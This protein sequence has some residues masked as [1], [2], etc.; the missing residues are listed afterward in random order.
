LAKAKVSILISFS[1]SM[2]NHNA[3][4]LSAFENNGLIQFE[5]YEGDESGL[6]FSLLTA[7][8]YV[9]NLHTYTTSIPAL[10]R[11]ISF[12]LSYDR[13]KVTVH[14][15]Q[16]DK[17][18][19]FEDGFVY[20]RYFSSNSYEI[21]GSLVGS[22]VETSLRHGESSSSGFPASTSVKKGTA[23]V[24]SGSFM[25]GGETS[26]ETFTR[27]HAGAHTYRSPDQGSDGEEEIL[28]KMRHSVDSLKEEMG[29][30][31]DDELLELFFRK[32]AIFY[33]GPHRYVPIDVRHGVTI[34]FDLMD[35]IHEFGPDDERCMTRTETTASLQAL[36]S[37]WGDG[38]PPPQL[39]S[40]YGLGNKLNQFLY[41][42]L[43]GTSK[44]P[45]L[46]ICLVTQLLEYESTCKKFKTFALN[47][48]ASG[49]PFIGQ[50][51]TSMK[52]VVTVNSTSLKQNASLSR[53]RRVL[54]SSNT[55][56]KSGNSS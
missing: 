7:D 53:G 45:Y 42:L 54:A 15:T 27:S 22:R 44:Y 55:S 11:F 6:M 32:V 41:G 34:H 40:V 47:L 21:S 50:L 8:R 35:F 5:P 10:G 46:F 2:D 23:S 25:E 33:K 14:E 24:S 9:V 28:L 30:G 39:T 43:P 12:E 52:T 16:V 36:M 3:I 19:Y 56:L 37:A 17:M 29:A 31:A 13:K 4:D 18:Y 49:S 1:A 48:Q 38:E 51:R 20:R 26:K